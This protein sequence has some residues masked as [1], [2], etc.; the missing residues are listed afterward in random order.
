MSGAGPRRWSRLLF[1]ISRYSEAGETRRTRK[2]KEIQ[3]VS[4]SQAAMI[5]ILVFLKMIVVLC[6]DFYLQVEGKNYIRFSCTPKA[7]VYRS[8]RFLG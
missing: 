8:C 2:N 4:S 5:Q 1:I 7:R 3:T 6:T